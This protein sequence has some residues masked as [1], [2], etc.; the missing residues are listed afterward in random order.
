M[1]IFFEFKPLYLHN[2]QFKERLKL[3]V[4]Y[5]LMDTC[6]MLL[7]TYVIDNATL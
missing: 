7:L 3:V 6:L 2:F 5:L 4:A 1:G